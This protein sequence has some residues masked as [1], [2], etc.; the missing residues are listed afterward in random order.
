MQY[1]CT[2]ADCTLVDGGFP[3]CSQQAGANNTFFGVCES[4]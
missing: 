3:Q 4:F 1:C 2:S